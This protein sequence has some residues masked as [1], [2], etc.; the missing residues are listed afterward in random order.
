MTRVLRFDKLKPHQ[1]T[2]A[3]DPDGLKFRIDPGDEIR[4]DHFH[5][6]SPATHY[7]ETLGVASFIEEPKKRSEQSKSNR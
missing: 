6:T 5:E 4:E 1:H 7:T 3:K 2:H